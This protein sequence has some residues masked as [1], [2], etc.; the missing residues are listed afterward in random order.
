MSGYLRA[1]CHGPR[2]L[3]AMVLAVFVEKRMGLD[4]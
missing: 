1:D 3:T 2:G 4:A